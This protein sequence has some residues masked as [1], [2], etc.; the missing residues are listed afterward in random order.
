[1]I[2]SRMTGPR[3]MTRIKLLPWTIRLVTVA[4]LLLGS[5]PGFRAAAGAETLSPVTNFYAWANRDWLGKTVIRADSPREDNFSQLEDSVN[6]QLRDLLVGLQAAPSRTPDQE[7]LVRLY[8]GFVAMDRRDARGIA[9]LA[10]ELQQIDGLKTHREVARLAA[11]F[12][13]IGVLSPVALVPLPDFKDSATIIG[14]VSQAGLGIERDYY[15]GTDDNALKQQRLYRAFLARLLRLAAV[16][17]PDVAA[18]KVLDLETK[19]AAIQW[20][21]VENRDLQKVY[22]PATVPEFLKQSAPFY[23]D[24]MLKAW[25]APR[26]AKL[27]I[28][29]PDYLEKYG[30][31]FHATP[32]PVWQD[33]LR[34]RL[35]MTYAGLLTSGFRAARVQY[36]KDLG[37]I[38]EE[39]ELWRQGI[40]FVS[41]TTNLM[42]GRAYVEK[43]FDSKTRESV[44]GLVLAI[45]ESFRSAIA[46][47]SWM[48]GE[49][50]RK[51]LDKLGKMQF[52][53]GYPDR[54]RDY[55]ALE[56]PGT[57]LAD[58]YRR[59]MRFEHQRSMAKI[60]RPA[61]RNEWDR[62]P[63]EINAF[64]DSTRN[65]FVLLAAILHDPFYRENGSAAQKYGGLGFVVA[66][67]IGHGFDDQGS[68]FDG[69]GNMR[70]WWADSD[71]RAYNVKKQ[72]LIAQADAYE[73]LPGTFLKGEQEIGEI[74]GD[75]SGAQ[76][77]LDAYRKT[78]D[79]SDRD[80]FI[81]LAQTWRSK[82][83]DEF[84]KMIIQ[85][86]THPPSEFRANG[87][88]KQF[89]AFHRSF[90]VKPGDKMYLAP[91]E[92]VLL[93]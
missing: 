33:Y 16:P 38:K 53:V 17:D 41:G 28:M 21:R 66:H 58:N 64:Y 24:E 6:A 74:M 37:L 79:A 22:N 59:A 19:L 73:I 10:G 80:F 18:G 40:D 43:Y 34:A 90:D 85:M 49:T 7:K 47:A 44:T 76:I 3:M 92:R 67:E 25:N 91:K 78:P 82:W 69:D 62:S 65:E 30:S 42:L 63:H 5:A 60:G 29:Q 48:S 8:D 93:W 14:F 27:N 46:N 39:K 75:L 11:H 4:V 54:W 26:D 81:Q 70:N 77:A 20:S 15:L 88:V 23:G 51:A 45:R 32:V 50:K 31:L 87:T 1:M 2:P 61:D 36:E 84:L 12:Q 57:D 9:P 86:D 72:R 68:R 55:S 56:I 83:R 13:T 89:D 71:A 35:L 52:K